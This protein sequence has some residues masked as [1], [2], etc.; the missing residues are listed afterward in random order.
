MSRL[1]NYVLQRI[2]AGWIYAITFLQ[3]SIEWIMTPHY[4]S[5]IYQIIYCGRTPTGIIQI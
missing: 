4:A 1:S 5:P 2:V 3:L